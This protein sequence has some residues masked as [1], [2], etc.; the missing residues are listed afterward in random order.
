MSMTREHD[1]KKE[2]GQSVTL[3][4]T[5]VAVILVGLLIGSAI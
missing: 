2:V 5:I 1:L 3:I 4:G